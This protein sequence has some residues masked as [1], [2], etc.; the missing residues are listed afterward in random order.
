MT[1]GQRSYD[2]KGRPLVKLDR[3]DRVEARRIAVRAQWLD[4]QRA[5]D[6]GA[7]DRLGSVRWA[8]PA[9]RPSVRLVVRPRSRGTSGVWRVDPV[10]IGQP[11]AGR[12]ALLLPSIAWSTTA[13]A[14]S[15]C[16]TSSTSWRCTG[17][18]QLGAGATSPSPSCTMINSSARS[19]PGDRPQELNPARSCHPRGRS[20]HPC[21]HLSRSGSKHLRP[22]WPSRP[23]R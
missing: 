18:R 5:A 1:Y 3:L 16:S 7:W 11:F 17:R 14:S 22:G 21:H 19:T 23:Q 13:N 12:T 9:H 15:S 10:A 6:L 4:A 20:L 8:S 2:A